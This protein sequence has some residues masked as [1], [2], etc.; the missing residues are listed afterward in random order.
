[1]YV[2]VHKVLKMK[3][4]TGNVSLLAVFNYLLSASFVT[5][6][7]NWRFVYGAWGGC[8]WPLN[9]NKTLDQV[10]E[11]LCE[12]LVAFI[13]PSKISLAV[14][15]L[16]ACRFTCSFDGSFTWMTPSQTTVLACR[17][18]VPNIQ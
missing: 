6:E 2:M 17:C 5:R 14:W 9:P 10:L 18:R 7:T 1:M 8:C 11:V 4:N 16:D 13:P 15:S 3:P 12:A